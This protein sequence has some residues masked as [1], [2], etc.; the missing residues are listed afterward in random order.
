[1][2]GCE[3]M[4]SIIL[5]SVSPVIGLAASARA[6]S[7]QSRREKNVDERKRRIELERS[8]N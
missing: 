3:R 2:Y 7:E 5:A 6:A 8:L 4:D 1:M